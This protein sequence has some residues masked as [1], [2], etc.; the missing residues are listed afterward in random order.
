[1]ISIADA[2]MIMLGFSSL[3]VSIIHLVVSI[4]KKSKK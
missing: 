3:T 1:M 2:L 4:D